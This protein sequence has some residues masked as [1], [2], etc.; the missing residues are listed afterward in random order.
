MACD[1]LDICCALSGTTLCTISPHSGCSVQDI[2]LEIS[3]FLRIPVLE[4][5]LLQ[6]ARVLADRESLQDILVGGGHA[7]HA[8]A[9]FLVRL[10]AAYVDALRRVSLQPDYLSRLPLEFTSDREI[11]KV[12][13]RNSGITLEFADTLLKSD[14][15][16]V[17]MAV[18]QDGSALQF[19]AAS[20]QAD[21]DIVKA[22]VETN[23]TAFGFAVEALKRDRDVSLHAVSCYPYALRFVVEELRKSSQFVIDALHLLDKRYVDASKSSRSFLVMPVSEC[24]RFPVGHALE[25][26]AVQRELD[27]PAALWHDKDVVLAVVALNGRFLEVVAEH[28][29][30]DID[31]VVKAVACNGEALRFASGRLRDNR[32]VVLLAV[33]CSGVAFEFASERLRA[34]REVVLVAVH[35]SE[36]SVLEHVSKDLLDD[37]EICWAAVEQDGRALEHVGD[38]LRENRDLILCALH[39][40]SSSIEFIPN[41]FLLDREVAMTAVTHFSSSC[42]ICVASFLPAK[43]QCEKEL[44][45]AAVTADSEALRHAGKELKNDRDIVMAA[46]KDGDDMLQYASKGLRNDPEVVLFALRGG[47]EPTVLRY[48]SRTLRSDFTFMRAAILICKD[49]YSFAANS[50]RRHWTANQI[51][52]HGIVPRALQARLV[53]RSRTFLGLNR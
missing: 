18:R 20:L 50:L 49:A 12:A 30:D 11:V 10:P 44:M 1:C 51:I 25:G 52:L 7:V 37:S 32:E 43:L 22:A 31:V 38:S 27:L 9:L 33:T 15:E 26:Y 42:R 3:T 36:E 28:L 53:D 39:H 16:V 45:L 21:K 14:K 46:L 6:K 17:L 40:D 48:A 5:R 4:L 19:A 47:G 2:K 34:D 24:R 29:H 13:V 35:N 23:Y 8:S 41:Q